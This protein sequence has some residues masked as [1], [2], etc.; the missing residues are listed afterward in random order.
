MPHHINN[1]N[2]HNICSFLK[3]SKSS[4]SGLV[5]LPADIIFP[6]LYLFI[7]SGCC[8]FLSARR[9]ENP[10]IV[11][12]T[13]KIGVPATKQTSKVQFRLA[14]V[15][16]KFLCSF[17][18]LKCYRYKKQCA[19]HT[20]LASISHKILMITENDNSVD[21]VMKIVYKSSSNNCQQDFSI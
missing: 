6:F 20:F 10:C 11:S 13:G 4:F 15:S 2:A 9:A 21:L 1:R 17:K 8:Q 7:I 14:V 19:A 16:D 18:Q 3:A 5:G 12:A